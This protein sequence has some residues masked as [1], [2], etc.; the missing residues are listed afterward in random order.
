MSESDKKLTKFGKW[1]YRNEVTQGEVIKMTGLSHVTVSSLFNNPGYKGST[2]TK[3]TV[4]SSL[5]KHGFDVEFAD[6]W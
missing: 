1:S 6:F 3:R 5:R 4:I 2:L